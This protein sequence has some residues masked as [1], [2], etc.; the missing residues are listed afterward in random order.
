[1]SDT[2]FSQQNAY[3]AISDLRGGPSTTPIESPGPSYYS[4]D[5]N[6]WIIT[7]YEHVRAALLHPHLVHSTPNWKGELPRDEETD[8]EYRH[9][10]GNTIRPARLDVWRNEIASFS[11]SLLGAV[12]RDCT[13]DLIPAFLKPWGL[14][15][16][17]L[18]TG[19]TARDGDRLALLAHDVFEAANEPYDEALRALSRPSTFE[20]CK[21]FGDA[22]PLSMQMFIAASQSVPHFVASAWFELLQHPVELERLR[23]EPDLVDTA[24]EELLRYS[25]VAR[26]V[27]RRA[28]RDL[29]TSGIKMIKGDLAILM[30]ASANRDP[31]AFPNPGQLSF[32]PRPTPHLAFGAG[33]HSCIGAQLI[34]L[35]A[36]EATR[37]FLKIPTTRIQGEI[38][39]RGFAHRILRSFPVILRS[40]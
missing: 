37:S 4:S 27:F 16:A 1:M 36:G 7:R 33:K 29:N 5:L 10:L 15:L 28:A 17:L 34:R 25:G 21:H 24:I 19:T 9:T 39:W 14:K 35:A 3:S 11:E 6:A 20:L 13:V 18:T 26:A 8:S 23:A 38:T 31:E 30:L 12:P 2:R 32:V 40:N 22:E